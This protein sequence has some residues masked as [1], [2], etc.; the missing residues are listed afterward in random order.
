MYVLGHSAGR[1]HDPEATP[2]IAKACTRRLQLAGWLCVLLLATVDML[3]QPARADS[4]DLTTLPIEQLLELSVSTASKFEQDRLAAPASTVVF[5]RNQIHR[6]GWRTL[7]DV[8]ENVPGMHVQSNRLYSFA[9]SRGLLRAGDYN[10][11]LLLLMDGVRIN[12]PIYDQAMIDGALPVDLEL[13][14]RIEVVKGPGSVLYGGNALMAVVNL[15]TRSAESLP[16]TGLQLG[17]GNQGYRDIGLHWAGPVGDDARLLI[18]GALSDRDGGSLY[19][20]E[21]DTPDQNNGRA[22]HLDDEHTRRL[23]LRLETGNWAL[24]LLHGYRQHGDPTASYEQRFNDPA[25]GMSDRSTLLGARWKRD[26]G[27]G[28]WLSTM[29]YGGEYRYRGVYAY[30]VGETTSLLNI[31]D[32]LTRWFGN[33]TQ[34]DWQVNTEHR[35]IA[36]LQ[37]QRDQPL[38]QRNYDLGADEPVLDVN[39]HRVRAGFYV[40]DQW[41]I[42]DPLTLNLGARYDLDSNGTRAIS[43]RGSAVYRPAPD[44]SLKLI[45][46]MAHRPA[47][48]YERDYSV[49]GDGGQQGNPHLRSEQL[50][51]AE[52]VAEQRLPNGHELSLSLYRYRFS[53][54]ISQQPDPESGVD[55]FVNSPVLNGSGAELRW[56]RRWDNSASLGAFV[57]LQRL[58]DSADDATPPNSPKTLAGLSAGSPRLFEHLLISGE[59]HYVSPR[60][61]REPGVRVPAYWRLDANLL[62]TDLGRKDTE[63]SLRVRNL[64]NTHYADPTGFDVLPTQLPQPGRAFWLEL[65]ARF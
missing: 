21:Y 2:H 4:R 25:S 28:L 42:A 39:D 9:G 40:E 53:H 58:K 19:L 11:R 10:T 31:D 23:L 50:R 29:F 60:L 49:S 27:N 16:G 26:L 59:A 37:L 15:I 38:R 12:D 22:E 48:A 24:Q 57:A 18:A 65:R 51:N 7:A 63:A 17:I 44:T 35:L 20:A 47:N 64:L 45:Y 41:Q 43:P 8:L 36:G 1:H 61:G 14:E 62:A 34:L 13:V 6:N 33:E 52:F 46:A 32:S 30:D 5:T 56:Q 54:L 3:M 55:I